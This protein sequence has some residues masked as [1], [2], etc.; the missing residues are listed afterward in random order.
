MVLGTAALREAIRKA[1][2]AWD[3]VV[4]AFG[5]LLQSE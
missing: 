2:R 4:A 5:L 1:K 3:F